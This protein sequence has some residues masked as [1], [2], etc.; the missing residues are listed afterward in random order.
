MLAGIA[1][2][3]V[4]FAI[5]ATNYPDIPLGFETATA[6]K[7]LVNPLVIVA[8]LALFCYITRVGAYIESAEDGIIA[9]VSGSKGQT[10]VDKF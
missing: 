2:V 3:P 10:E 8:A 7:L 6:V 1:L 5:L 9:K 4:I